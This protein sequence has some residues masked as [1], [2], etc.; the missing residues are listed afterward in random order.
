MKKNI[1]ILIFLVCAFFSNA[2]HFSIT[3]KTSFWGSAMN[4]TLPWK[5]TNATTSPI[6]RTIQTPDGP[7]ETLLIPRQNNKLTSIGIVPI[8]SKKG[9]NGNC[10]C[11]HKAGQKQ[12]GL[13]LNLD[14]DSWGFSTGFSYNKR[15][16]N[17][18]YY[19]EIPDMWQFRE[20]N[21]INS[22]GLPIIVKF[23]SMY[24]HNYGYMGFTYYVNQDLTQIHYIVGEEFKS[25]K[26]GATEIKPSYTNFVLGWNFFMAF[27]EMTFAS[28]RFFR[29]D[30][31]EYSNYK[32][33]IFSFNAG[34]AVPIDFRYLSNTNIYQS[35]F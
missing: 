9:N 20:D 33:L 21:I 26:T 3:P 32:K 7:Q 31:L 16:I 28:N 1:L 2:Q 30:A 15:F 8:I 12:Y 23:G 22:Y 18:F 13:W 5:F 24:D 29:K 11:N 27:V 10:K 14:W 19:T 17:E 35:L 34:I 25:I 4:G 6:T